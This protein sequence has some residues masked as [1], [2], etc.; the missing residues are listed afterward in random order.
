VFSNKYGVYGFVFLVISFM[1]MPFSLLG[2]S[3]FFLSWLFWLAGLVVPMFGLK[4]GAV[5]GL[6][7]VVIVNAFIHLILR[8]VFYFLVFTR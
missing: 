1:S 8:V 3:Y 6:P 5:I 4:K 7:I 2:L